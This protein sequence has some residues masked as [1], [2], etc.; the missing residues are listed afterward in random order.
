[1]KDIHQE[2]QSAPYLSHQKVVENSKNLRFVLFKDLMGS[3]TS[4]GFFRIL[5]SG[6]SIIYLDTS[7]NNY[8]KTKKQKRVF[9]RQTS[10]K[11][12][13]LKRSKL[14]QTF[15]EESA[16]SQNN[17]LKQIKSRKKKA[18]KAEHL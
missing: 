2:K 1:L 7:K 3:G 5:V 12:N 6:S 8:I 18:S 11:I 15:S 10:R 13:A 17:K 9:S 14:A 16:D 4:K